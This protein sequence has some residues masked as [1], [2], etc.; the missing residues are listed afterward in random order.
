MP[1]P[2]DHRP[3]TGWR[4][5]ISEAGRLNHLIRGLVILPIRVIREARGHPGSVLRDWR[6]PESPEQVLRYLALSAALYGFVGVFGILW[7]FLSLIGAAPMFQGILLL[8]IGLLA[9]FFVSVRMWQRAC[10]QGGQWHPYK[11]WLAGRKLDE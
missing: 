4:A 7:G 1:T 8:V 10:I 6:P 2:H 3:P 5:V 9:W 11:H